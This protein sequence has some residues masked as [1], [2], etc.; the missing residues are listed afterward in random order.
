MKKFSGV[1]SLKKDTHKSQLDFGIDL[2]PK[3][4][5]KD[6]ILINYSQLRSI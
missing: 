5:E 2:I 3:I 6:N 4:L 1:S